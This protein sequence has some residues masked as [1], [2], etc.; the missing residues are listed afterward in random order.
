MVVWIVNGDACQRAT[1]TS[2]RTGKQPHVMMTTTM[3]KPVLAYR[4]WAEFK[5]SCHHKYASN[6]FT[7]IV[8]HRCAVLYEV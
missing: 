5:R 4:H 1:E 3:N 8:K 2:L 6:K 7:Q